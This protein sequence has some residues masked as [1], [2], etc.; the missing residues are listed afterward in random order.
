MPK[1][2]TDYKIPFI[3]GLGLLTVLVAIVILE[4]PMMPLNNTSVAATS[5][6]VSVQA[7]VAQTASF[8]IAGVAS[9][10]SIATGASS[11][12]VSTTFDTVDLG[13]LS[14]SSNAIGAQ[15]LIVSTNAGNGYTIDVKYDHTLQSSASS[16][17]DIDDWT[18]TNAA[19]TDMWAA[20]TEAFGYTTA[21]PDYT[22]FGTGHKWAAFTG[23]DEHVATASGPVDSD[24][25]RIGYAV[26]I[27]G[28]T[29]AHNDYGDTITYTFTASF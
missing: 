16:S 15:D 5:S 4:G 1:I 25:T 18:G 10:A 24:T 19:P 22:Q 28:L 6:T 2:K 26:G 11:T 17:D 13:T 14:L 7:T 8:S 21:D 29:V 20:G 3:I 9:G 23:T 27:S 12:N